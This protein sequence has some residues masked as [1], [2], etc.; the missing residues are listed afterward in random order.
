[1]KNFVKSDGDMPTGL[2]PLVTFVSLAASLG[3]GSTSS[4][5][6]LVV[7]VS[8]DGTVDADGKLD[9]LFMISA[10]E[11]CEARERTRTKGFLSIILRPEM[12]KA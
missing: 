2:S 6:V 8:V 9:W 7:V 1:M 5:S 4:V 3:S 10:L 11:S 12:S